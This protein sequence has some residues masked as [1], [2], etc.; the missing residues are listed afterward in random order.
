[1]SNTIFTFV[2]TTVHIL[3]FLD[4]DRQT[5]PTFNLVIRKSNVRQGSKTEYQRL[6]VIRSN[7][8]NLYK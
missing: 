6:C 5:I 8:N 3:S 7:A 1:M 4:K 2:Y